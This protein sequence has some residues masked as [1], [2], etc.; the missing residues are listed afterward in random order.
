[1]ILKPIVPH[2]TRRQINL[3]PSQ[4]LRTSTFDCTCT[5]KMYQLFF[6]LKLKRIRQ[7]LYAHNNI[8][9]LLNNTKYI[10]IN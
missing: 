5:S 8:D 9:E 6:F 7:Q 10:N 3:T 2:T 1:M 4:R